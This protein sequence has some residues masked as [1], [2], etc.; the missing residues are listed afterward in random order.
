[1]PTQARAS[2]RLAPRTFCRARTR[3]GRGGARREGCASWAQVKL[4][5]AGACSTCLA[6]REARR[7]VGKRPRGESD[8]LV[9]PPSLSAS[10]H[11]SRAAMLRRAALRAALY[12]IPPRTGS[13]S[14][15]VLRHSSPSSPSSSLP[16]LR[17]TLAT[18]APDL[19]PYD[20]L[21]IGA[22]HA[23]CEAAAASA[24]SGARTALITQSL[25]TVGGASTFRSSLI[26]RAL[27]D[28][29]IT[30]AEMSCNPSF[31]GASLSPLSPLSPCSFRR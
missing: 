30:P 15:R 3:A 1:M 25:D 27:A 24:R 21:V 19:Q 6:S 5:G 29:E 26:A 8:R 14:A 18:A 20:T 28:S 31:G 16:P 9:E 10:T 7:V 23:G 17:R 13:T 12:S 4:R 11:P 2:C 22:G